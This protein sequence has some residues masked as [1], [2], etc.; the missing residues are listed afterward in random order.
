[1]SIDTFRQTEGVLEARISDDELVLLGPSSEEYVGLDG[2]GAAVWSRLH[3]TCR[4]DHLVRSLAEE[5]DAS[6]ETIAA[7]VRALIDELVAS[8]LVER[9]ETDG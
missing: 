9:E 8:G 6:L 4:F 1:M 5:Y 3:R 2:V 7:D